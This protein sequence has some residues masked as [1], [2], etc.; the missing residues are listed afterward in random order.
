MASIISFHLGDSF[1]L[2]YAAGNCSLQ[3]LSL[4]FVALISSTDFLCNVMQHHFHTK[5]FGVL[6]RLFNAYTTSPVF[7]HGWS[8]SFSH[9]ELPVLCHIHSPPLFFMPSCKCLSCISAVG[10]TVKKGGS[11]AHNSRT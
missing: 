10:S 4:E 6:V 5:K 8:G 3:R 9:S 2:W 7:C 11:V 1:A